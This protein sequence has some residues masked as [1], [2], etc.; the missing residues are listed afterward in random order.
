MVS[1]NNRLAI[2]KLESGSYQ[3]DR[4]ISLGGASFTARDIL[5]KA[6]LIARLNAYFVG[7]TGRGKTQLGNDLIGCFPDSS[8]YAMGRPDFEPSE[9]LKQMRLDKIKNAVTDRDLVQLTENVRKN[10]FFIDELNRAP[11][12]VQNYF[13]DFF[14]GKLVHDGR[15]LNLGTDGY[16]VGFATGNLGDGEYVG[17]S[18]SDRALKDRMHLIVKLDHPDY[19]AR[20]V[21][22][23]DVF[24]GKRSPQSDMPTNTKGITRE[25]I[26]ALN[27]EF[28]GRETHPILPILGVYFTEGLDYL[29]NV[30]GNSKIACDSR[31]SNLEGIKTDNDE[32]KL[33][34][35]SP[36]G[37]LSAIA[38]TGALQ[39]IGEAKGENP[40]V[41]PLFLDALRFTIPYS[42]VMAPRY[43]E[44]EHGGDVYSAFDT[45]LGND[46]G[47]RTEISE[48]SSKL[49]EAVALAEAGVTDADL[50]NDISP[51]KGKWSPV[52]EAIED[53]AQ[54]NKLDN[55][56]ARVKL[57]EIVEQVHQSGGG[58]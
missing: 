12:I 52:R 4:V 47:N 8:C 3:N 50:L 15:I 56:S 30:K 25:E 11:P 6:P 13:F 34:P 43:V 14:D 58:K 23:L 17:V 48:K 10:L 27:R 57:R 55:S 29:E 7:G 45:L 19:R 33:F 1:E 36:R 53:Y 24:R 41:I 5:V 42:G 37:V 16:S 38:L 22:L 20:P 32:N 9:L 2:E 44:Q 46:S 21:N 26:L 49:E 28:K 40:Q 35:L 18:D 51:V 39:M 31:W 54:K